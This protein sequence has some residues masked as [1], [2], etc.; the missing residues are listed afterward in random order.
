MWYRRSCTLPFCNR[1]EQLYGKNAVTPNMHLHCH[2]SKCLE[3]F[4][5]VYGFWLFSFEKKYNGILG[6]YSTNNRSI[7]IQLMRKFQTETN[8]LSSPPAKFYP[9]NDFHDIFQAAFQTLKC[10]EI[11]DQSM[12]SVLKDTN[13]LL[14]AATCKLSTT[15]HTKNWVVFESIKPCSWSRIITFDYEEKQFLYQTY[16]IL[17]LPDQLP[18]INNTVITY[19]QHESVTIGDERYMSQMA[20]RT[21]QDRTMSCHF[22]FMGRL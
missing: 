20:K 9:E 16:K 5:S 11:K 18:D 14:E 13:N 15:A 17:Y 2:L 6:N 22:G 1:F 19:H 8:L 10:I 7:E 3:D 21:E 4:G 12:P